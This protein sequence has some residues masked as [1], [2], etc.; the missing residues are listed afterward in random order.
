MTDAL[1]ADVAAEDGHGFK[2]RRGVFAAADAYAEGLDHAASF[3]AE[4]V[5]RLSRSGRLKRTARHC[6]CDS[7]ALF[8]PGGVEVVVFAY[9]LV[10]LFDREAGGSEQLLV[11]LGPERDR[12]QFCH[13]I[14]PDRG[15]GC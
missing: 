8:S 6:V 15:L 4:R 14:G 9:I 11:L 7:D 3:E 10:L 13:C 12:L 2:E 5:V 1:E